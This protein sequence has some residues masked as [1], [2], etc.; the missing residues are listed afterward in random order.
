MWCGAVRSHAVWCG[1]NL[2]GEVRAS[3]VATRRS[4]NYS[5]QVVVG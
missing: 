4:T 3:F 2:G 5:F 1:E